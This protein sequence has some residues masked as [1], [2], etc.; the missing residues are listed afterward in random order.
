MKI[1]IFEAG[2]TWLGGRYLDF[3]PNFREV[4]AA[5][6]RRRAALRES[7]KVWEKEN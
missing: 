3:P 5:L 1:K 4:K 2:R 6:E 7:L